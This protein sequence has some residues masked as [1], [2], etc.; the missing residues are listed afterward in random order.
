MDQLLTFYFNELLKPI[1][2]Y[3]YSQQTMKMM[4]FQLKL[5]TWVLGSL[6]TFA[7]IKTIKKN[8]NIFVKKV[9]IS[10]C[11]ENNPLTW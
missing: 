4:W 9:K 5:T 3:N 6:G 2:D 11:Y 1:D 8:Y 10:K 7:A